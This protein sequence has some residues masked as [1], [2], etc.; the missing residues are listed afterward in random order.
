[1]PW[2]ATV[3]NIGDP[4]TKNLSAAVCALLVLTSCSPSKPVVLPEARRWEPVE[5]AFQANVKAANPFLVNFDALVTAPDGRELRVPGFFDGNDVWKARVMPSSEGTWTVVTNSAEP[6]L[7]GRRFEFS[8]A[9]RAAPAQHGRLTVDGE[10]PHHFKFEDGTRHFML[11]YECDWLWALDHGDATMPKTKAFLD[12]IASHGFNTVIVNTF[13]YDTGWRTGKTEPDDLGPPAS[14]PWLGTP[15]KPDHKRLNPAFWQHYDRMIQAM[16]DRGLIAHVL[17]KVYNKRVKWPKRGSEADELFFRTLIA[18]Y[19]AFPGIVWDFAKEAHNEKDLDYKVG[20]LRYLRE[21]D[22]YRHLVT[23]HDDD[24]NYGSGAFDSLVDFRTDQQHDQFHAKVLEQRAQRAWPVMNSEFG[25]EQGAGGPEDKTYG[26]VQ[27]PEVFAIRAWEVA[28]AGGYTA[29]YHTHTA[30][31]V[32]RTEVDP[33]GYRLFGLMRQFFETTNYWE[34]SPATP[35]SNHW[36]LENPGREYVLW[37]GDG[38]APGIEIPN[39]AGGMRVRWF[40][41]LTGEESDGGIVSSG[42]RVLT[43]PAAWAGSPVVLNLKR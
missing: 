13:A 29:Y 34:L 7:H 18:R 3:R 36:T 1:M 42:A 9:D 12:R 23:I 19:S 30:W 20:R 31:D 8:C 28:M 2:W 14:M 40:R 21:A 32:L 24:K 15:E 41:P 43:P 16:H 37:L 11:A 22:P 27:S 6:A 26:V 35:S 10:H 39:D 4:M 25:Y 17:C 5:L 33:P 38:R